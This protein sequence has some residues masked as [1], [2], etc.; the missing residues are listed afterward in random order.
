MPEYVIL[1]SAIACAAA[2]MALYFNRENPALLGAVIISAIALLYGVGQYVE[3]SKSEPNLTA[4]GDAADKPVLKEAVKEPVSAAREKP[5]PEGKELAAR[6]KPKEP[7]VA[8]APP[9][10]P[11]AQPQVE[12]KQEEKLASAQPTSPGGWTPSVV[13]SNVTSR[14]SAAAKYVDVS[15]TLTNKNLFAVKNVVVR[16]GDKTYASGD[17]SAMV[18]QVVPPR[19]ELKISGLR[20]GPIRPEL[21]PTECQ[22][23]KFERAD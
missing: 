3:R 18:E 9:P 8:S 5:K 6:D 22:I 19:S 11:L 1:L 23:A 10:P 4:I 16:C 21:P 7:A 15:G 14:K 12:A 17:V 20:M 2:G 13:I